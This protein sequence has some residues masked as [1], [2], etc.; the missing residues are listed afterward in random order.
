MSSANLA[1]FL[2]ALRYPDIPQPAIERTKELFLDW[3]GS[4]L[5]GANARPVKVLNDFA[6]TMGPS[7]GASE[8]LVSGEL[9]TGRIASLACRGSFMMF[10]RITILLTPAYTP[11]SI[12]LSVGN[13]PMFQ[14]S[15]LL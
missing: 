13:L 4:T 14:M 5:A 15:A 9:S 2:A 10:S 8:V 1:E 12:G 6:R 7:T 3:V 11:G